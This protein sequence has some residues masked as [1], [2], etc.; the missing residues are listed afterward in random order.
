[1][2]IIRCSKKLKVFLDRLRTYAISWYILFEDKLGA[3]GHNGAA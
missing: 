3:Q 1:M 2:L